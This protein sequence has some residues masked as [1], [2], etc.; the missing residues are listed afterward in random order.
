MK[1]SAVIVPVASVPFVRPLDQQW[2]WALRVEPHHDGTVHVAGSHVDVRHGD[3][4]DVGH[5]EAIVEGCPVRRE[6]ELGHPSGVR[7]D[8]GNLLVARQRRDEVARRCET[9]GRQ[10]D[11]EG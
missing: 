7:V 6:L 1:S 9:D 8:G 5:I 4:L 3:V 11:D 2:R 10:G